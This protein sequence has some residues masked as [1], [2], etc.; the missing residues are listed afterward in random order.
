M[1]VEAVRRGFG[2]AGLDPELLRNACGDVEQRLAHNCSG[3]HLGFLTISKL[4]GWPLQG[5]RAAEHPSQRAALDVMAHALGRPA[6][7]S[8]PVPTAAACWPL[9]C[10]CAR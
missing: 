2:L 1:H 4:Q 8:R 5:Y 10:R 9:R 3:N 6:E 7:T